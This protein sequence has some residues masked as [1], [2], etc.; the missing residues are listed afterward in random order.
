M[1]IFCYLHY[2]PLSRWIMHDKMNIELIRAG[3]LYTF[4]VHIL[5]QIHA[6]D[7]EWRWR[8]WCP[9]NLSNILARSKRWEKTR[10]HDHDLSRKTAHRKKIIQKGTSLYNVSIWLRIFLFILFF[11]SFLLLSDSFRSQRSHTTRISCCRL[12]QSRGHALVSVRGY[13]IMCTLC[14]SLLLSC[15]REAA[16][17]LTTKSLLQELVGNPWKK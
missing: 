15:G 9:S 12:A 10:V 3:M 7:E 2:S 5:I 8:W 1:V 4:F 17:V 13:I 11:S 14:I 16:F 6:L